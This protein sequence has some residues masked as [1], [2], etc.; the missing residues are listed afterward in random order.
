[1]LNLVLEQKTL[2]VTLL[3]GVR[4]EWGAHTSSENMFGRNTNCRH[5]EPPTQRH[6]DT[7]TQRD[8]KTQTH[9]YRNTQKHIQT[10][11]RRRTL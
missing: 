6:R 1:M 3:K 9:K 8:R 2:P 4:G 5:T 10:M 11:R 7:E